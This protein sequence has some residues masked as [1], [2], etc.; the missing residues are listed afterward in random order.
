MQQSQV[1]NVA[2]KVLYAP[3]FVSEVERILSK[4]TE[5]GTVGTS[6]RC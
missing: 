2:Y 5:T 3:R 4:N 6:E 1:I